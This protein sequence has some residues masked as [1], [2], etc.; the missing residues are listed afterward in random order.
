MSP[1]N[2]LQYHVYLKV[3]ACHCSIYKH[4]ALKTYEDVVTNIISLCHVT[5]TIITYMPSLYCQLKKIQVLLGVAHSSFFICKHHK[6]GTWVSKIENIVYNSWFMI[7]IRVNLMGMRNNLCI[8]SSFC[9]AYG[10]HM[11]IIL[12]L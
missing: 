6:E 12:P 3:M 4:V 1:L 7:R 9:L 8:D 10:I 11:P 5:I 2:V